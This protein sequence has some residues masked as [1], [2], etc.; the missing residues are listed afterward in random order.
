M[1]N[2]LLVSDEDL[3]R[4]RMA[5]ALLADFGRG[6]HLFTAGV[7]AGT[8]ISQLV[9]EVMEEHGQEISH[10]APMALS[11]VDLAQMD[12]VVT[13]TAEAQEAVTALG[14]QPVKMASLQI[15]DPFRG[16][17]SVEQ[18]REALEQTYEELHRALFRLYR[19]VLSDM[20]M[21]TCTCG[22]NTYC[23]CE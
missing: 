20:L 4:S 10:S 7:V 2:I 8:T 1:K 5:K 19:N 12:F 23:R 9:D 15:A 17:G 14:V 11:S 13:L 3:C 6:M 22:A 18:K 16:H 21:P